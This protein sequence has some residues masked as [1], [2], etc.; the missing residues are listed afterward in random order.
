MFRR[1][2]QF[3][4]V[5]IVIFLV[6]IFLAIIFR[7]VVAATVGG[8]LG[9]QEPAKMWMAPRGTITADPAQVWQAIIA[10]ALM[11]ALGFALYRACAI[12][13]EKRTPNE[14]AIKGAA[15]YFV[16]G[17]FVGIAILLFVV[18]TLALFG[19]L[20]TSIRPVTVA[21]LIPLAAAATAAFMEELLFRGILFRYLE[22]W[23]GSWLALLLTASLFG[24][25]HAFNPNATMLSTISI[26]SLAGVA[27]GLAYMATRSLW[28]PIGIHFAV[29]IMQGTVLGLPVSGKET[30]GVFASQLEGPVLLTGG[31]FGLE[32]SILFF[33]P[34]VVVI[35]ILLWLTRKRQQM[36]PPMWKRARKAPTPIASETNA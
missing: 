12:H 18:I 22:G 14:L 17:I 5:Q 20:Q 6:G 3:G 32:A 29:N 15:A 27:L 35:A 31:E 4:P 11:I 30:V 34:G 36:L 25:G 28:F 24:L 16:Q 21:V 8:A 2:L 33:P 9:V 26:A 23:L 1:L 7:D 19:M 10:A 13:V